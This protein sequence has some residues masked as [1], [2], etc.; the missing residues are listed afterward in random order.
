MTT[1]HS[2]STERAA[3]TANGILML[4]LGLLLLVGGPVGV[5]QNPDS[6]LN[7]V[8]GIVAAG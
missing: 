4:L 3:S 1:T 8:T 7:V 5:A 2:K 6:I